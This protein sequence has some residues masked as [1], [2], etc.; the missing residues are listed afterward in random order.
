[1]ARWSRRRPSRPS[2]WAR[3][4]SSFRPD[5]FCRRRKWARKRLASWWWRMPAR[6][7]R[8]PTCSA[9]SAPSRCGSPKHCRVTAIDSDQPAIDALA[10]AAQ[11]TP[12]LKPVTAQRR[13]LFRGPLSAL[14][15]SGFDA[16]VF[17]PP[18]QG[19][20]AQ[21]REIAKSKCRNVIAVS[22]NA[23]TFARDAAL[24]IGRRLSARA[25][26]AGRSVQI[27]RACRDRRA[28]RAVSATASCPGRSAARA[29]AKRCAAEPGP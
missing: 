26:D 24:L 2:A 9:G 13:D 15:L 27:H 21:A 11:S 10:R 14:E 12:G 3:H 17:D 28:F 4:W 8:S 22:C 19:A 6:R 23:A 20:E 7:N 18:R 5:P 16:I 29:L 25:R 1:M